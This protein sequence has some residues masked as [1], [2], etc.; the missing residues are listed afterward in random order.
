MYARRPQDPELESAQGER[1]LCCRCIFT[2]ATNVRTGYAQYCCSR[3]DDM[4]F[5]EGGMVLVGPQLLEPHLSNLGICT[6]KHCCYLQMIG[7]LRQYGTNAERLHPPC[8]HQLLQL[9]MDLLVSHPHLYT[10][11]RTTVRYSQ[12]VVHVYFRDQS[13]SPY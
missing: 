13:R 1:F 2:R 4:R 6:V 5:S 9:W 7:L 10:T 3:I 8:T 12:F 11:C